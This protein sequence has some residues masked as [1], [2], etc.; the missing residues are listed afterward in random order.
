MVLQE[1]AVRQVGVRDRDAL[2]AERQKPL[3]YHFREIGWVRDRDALVQ[4]TNPS[5]GIVL[6]SLCR[7]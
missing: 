7:E 2:A 5:N 1:R 4:T 3:K 6:Q